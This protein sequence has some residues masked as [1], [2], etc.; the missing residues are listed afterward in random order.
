MNNAGCF[1]MYIHTFPIF[2]SKYL[3]YRFLMN[4]KVDMVVHQTFFKKI[5][6]IAS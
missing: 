3:E 4:V 5:N 6:S 2:L 1:N